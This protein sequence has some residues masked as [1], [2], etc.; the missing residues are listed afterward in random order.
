MLEGIDYRQ[1][2]RARAI[3][4]YQLVQPIHTGLGEKDR[5]LEWWEKAYEERSWLILYLKTDPFFDSLR[6]E[7]RFND[8]LRRAGI[9]Q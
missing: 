2:V 9:P 3:L 1:I 6:S 7:P 8:L 4:F 5:A